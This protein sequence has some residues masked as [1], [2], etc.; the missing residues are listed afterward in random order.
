MRMLQ[1]AFIKEAGPQLSS[2]E[3][4]VH[5]AFL[6]FI[7]G[8]GIGVGVSSTVSGHFLLSRSNWV[9]TAV[10]HSLYDQAACVRRLFSD[11]R[12]YFSGE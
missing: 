10:S 1:V 2:Q 11:R 7:D 5:G 12:I 8:F 6:V 4:F 9:L 3:A